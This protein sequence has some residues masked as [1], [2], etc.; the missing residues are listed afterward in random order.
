MMYIPVL[1]LMFIHIPKNAG[2]SFGTAVK[3]LKPQK[4][5]NNLPS[6]ASASEIHKSVPEL[7]GHTEKAAIVRNPWDRLVSLWKYTTHPKRI[8]RETILHSDF[9]ELPVSLAQVERGRN[10]FQYWLFT[11]CEHHGW[12][13]FGPPQTMSRTP[14][15]W[16]LDDRV[17]HVFRFE[18][19]GT[20]LDF[21]QQRTNVPLVWPHRNATKHAHYRTYYN[22]H[23]YDYVTEHYHSDI[24]RFGYV[25]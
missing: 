24:R 1:R 16:W 12:R 23:T 11:L 25:F 9:F 10:D 13:I 19:M 3:P 17:E 8:N 15:T 22:N 21:L 20:I 2:T 14:Q 4:N 7:W 6:H 18:D 5:I